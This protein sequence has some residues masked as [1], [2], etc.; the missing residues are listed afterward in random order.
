MGWESQFWE[1]ARATMTPGAD[2][3]TLD[4]RFDLLCD[5]ESYFNLASERLAIH[6]S[7]CPGFEPLL[8]KHLLSRMICMGTTDKAVKVLLN[9]SDPSDPSFYEDNL[10][11]CLVSMSAAGGCGENYSTITASDNTIQTNTIK[12]VATNLIA[13]GKL[14]EG[15][16]LLCLI[17]KVF[18]ACQYLQ[19]SNEWY[20]SMWLA[21]CGLRRP[22]QKG[23]LM[24]IVGK[25]CDHLV[26]HGLR[27]EAILLQL[28]CGNYVG[29]LDM[30]L[31]GKMILLASHFL[32]LVMEEL[33]LVDP[34]TSHAMVISEE[35]NLARAR[36][37]YFDCGNVRAA[38]YYCD[39]ADEKGGILKKE[40]E[41]LMSNTADDTS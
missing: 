25:Y 35:I 22:D 7:R 24:K 21:K 29:V 19:A 27:Q 39:K 10:R 13:E 16:E 18:D 5:N 6:E 37:A 30:L 8:K 4:S 3:S 2:H 9:T 14:W 26:S 17:Q 36:H 38:F 41:M 28:S 11:A 15:V 31:A 33:K 40:I 32:Y 34:D 12:L 23:S 20:A 1:I